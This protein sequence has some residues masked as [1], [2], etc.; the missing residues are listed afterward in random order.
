MNDPAAQTTRD[1]GP[2]RV[3]VVGQVP[4]TM[5]ASWS[6]GSARVGWGTRRQPTRSLTGTLATGLS[7]VREKRKGNPGA[8]SERPGGS[9][10]RSG[11]RRAYG[12]VVGLCRASSA[13]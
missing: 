5:R 6:V 4:R 12:A 10:V 8:T 13:K 1:A 3:R 2:R 9:R 11:G 7:V